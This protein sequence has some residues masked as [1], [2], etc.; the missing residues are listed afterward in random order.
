[1]Q[2][3]PLIF[4]F[5]ENEQ[6]SLEA[7][8]L[9]IVTG[10]HAFC[11]GP[12]IGQDR[13]HAMHVEK[14][15]MVEK[16]SNVARISFRSASNKASGTMTR[17]TTLDVQH[18]SSDEEELRRQQI[19]QRREK[20]LAFYRRFLRCMLI[21]LVFWI[22]MLYFSAHHE[23]GLVIGGFVILGMWLIY[24]LTCICGSLCCM[25]QQGRHSVVPTIDEDAEDAGLT[26]DLDLFDEDESF[27]YE[28]AETPQRIRECEHTITPG[29]GPTNGTYAAVYSAVY[30]NKS[31]RS[32]GNLHLEFSPTHDNGWTVQG[33]SSF[34]KV[35]RV[36]LEGFVNAKGEMYWKTPQAIHRGNLDFSRS[37]MWD[38]EFTPAKKG[39][40]GRIVRLELSKAE[41]YSSDTSS[42][43]EMVNFSSSIDDGTKEDE[44]LYV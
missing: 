22:V 18:P 29:V 6:T 28:M 25:F 8:P 11:F 35:Q 17:M 26:R 27:P 30:F 4:I 14:N 36:V 38:G 37:C 16:I 34:G 33:E 43:V 39:P 40:N 5:F 21:A 44:G 15:I 9:F 20:E 24:M 10:G 2:L 3:T 19:K 23:N 31:V 32:E 1:L 13:F 42:S 7:R 41:F 12:E